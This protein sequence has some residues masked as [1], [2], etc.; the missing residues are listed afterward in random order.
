[1]SK[2]LPG[3]DGKGCELTKAEGTAYTK[4]QKFRNSMVSQEKGKW[5]VLAR[6]QYMLRGGIGKLGQ[7]PDCG[8]IQGH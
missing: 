2:Y 7:R 5:S 1:M 4:A 6:T 8:D 3:T